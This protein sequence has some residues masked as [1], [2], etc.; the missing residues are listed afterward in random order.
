MLESDVPMIDLHCHILPGL[1]D[2]SPDLATSLA[3]ARIAL[4]DGIETI[5]ATPHWLVDIG[6]TP[7]QIR[8]AAQQLQTALVDHN[9][10]LTVLPGAEVR[11]DPELPA[12]VRRDEVM[13]LA[14]DGRYLLLEPPFIGIPNYLEQLCF[15]L[16]IAGITPIL[17]HPERAEVAQRE[18]ELYERLVARGCLIQVNAPSLHGDYGRTIAEIAADLIRRGLAHIV[19]SDAHNATSRPPVL[20]DARQAVVQAAGEAA[21]RQM[22]ELVPSRIIAGR[23][24]GDSTR[25]VK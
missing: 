9:I 1:D 22:T 15:E 13:T 25:T 19:A 5:V 23:Q 16:Q 7:A 11:A 6:P 10:P 24:A 14:D 18:P 8:T 20:S 17:A 2:G 3:M 21:F 4:D 12:M